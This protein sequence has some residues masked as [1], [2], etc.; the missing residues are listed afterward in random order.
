MI[1]KQVYLEPRQD[2]SLKASAA[3][4]GCTEAEIIRD[5]LDRL[6]DPSESVEE[7]LAAAGMLAPK[8]D[9]SDALRGAVL[10]ALEAEVEA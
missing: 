4:R 10:R 2:R 5:D 3:R 9:V 1:R 7:Q 6:P 8:G